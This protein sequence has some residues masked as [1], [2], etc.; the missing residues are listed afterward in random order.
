VATSGAAV[1]ADLGDFAQAAAASLD[2]RYDLLM[3][4]TPPR[5]A[6]SRFA[7]WIL[8]HTSLSINCRFGA[9]GTLL[10]G[11]TYSNMHDLAKVHAD[12][13]GKPSDEV[14]RARLGAYFEKR[15]AFDR[16]FVNG[17]QFNYAAL[18][19]SGCSLT[20]YGPICLRLKPE[21]SA[22]TPP[23][24]YVVG[25]TLDQYTTTS[26]PSVDLAKLASSIAPHSHR[27]KLAVLAFGSTI[28]T[29]PG[30]MWGR[31]ICKKTS[32]IESIFISKLTKADVEVYEVSKDE[33]DL[34]K[35][36]LYRLVFGKADDAEKL[37]AS[38][39]SVFLTMADTGELRIEVI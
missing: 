6:L 8:S 24:A 22:T 28:A 7:S 20:A 15:M 26:P 5:P 27:H 37:A 30:S 19:S 33:H 3:G 4:A 38:L 9:V 13:I 34:M 12:H 35:D 21:F 10:M 23:L 11:G 14:L 2:V 18:T 17:D 25:D 1:K 29:S 36:R 31:L 16:Q 39:Y 32:Y